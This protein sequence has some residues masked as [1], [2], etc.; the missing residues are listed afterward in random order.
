ME[1]SDPSSGKQKSSLQII[2][3][4]FGIMIAIST[5]TLPLFLILNLSQNQLEQS[6]QVSKVSRWQP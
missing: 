6:L 1:I 4:L 5:L 3:D 2:S